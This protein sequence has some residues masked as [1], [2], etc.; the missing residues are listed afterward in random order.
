MAKKQITKGRKTVNKKSQ[1]ATKKEV[2]KI[3]QQVLNAD[4]E[5]KFMNAQS[6]TSLQPQPT[7][8]VQENGVW[9]PASRVSVLAFSNTV[10][11]SGNGVIQTYGTTGDDSNDLPMY[12]LEM[13]RPFQDTGNLGTKPY[14]IVGKEA[15]PVSAVNKWR[16]VRD[17]SKLL[18]GEYLNHQSS[19]G[20]EQ[21]LVA[22]LELT[23]SL[24]VICRMIRVSPKL[25]QTA[26]TV[27]PA[28]DLFLD[29]H[30]NIIG[31]ESGGFDDNEVLNYKIND[32]RYNVIQDKYFK[33]QNGLTVQWNRAVWSDG[34][35]NSRAMVQ[36][37]ITN[38]NGNC[39]K[40]LTTSHQL[41][42][43]KNGT[44]HYNFPT[45]NPITA[46]SGMRRE[47][48]LFHFV[49]AGAETYLNSSSTIN[50]CPTDLRVSNK[51]V[52]QFTDI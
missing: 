48:I 44:I 37:L 39:E 41:T 16:I 28:V 13:T 20:S 18:K 2:R 43:R 15:K 52:V 40:S 4:V 26:N 27:F 17:I 31:V 12:E 14:H 45:N 19:G 34:T 11:Q 5:R 23:T 24:P 32:R 50:T 30:S 49:Y 42:S 21:E 6:F 25:N 47:Y 1:L 51:N 22:P 35:N 9:K 29:T 10:N 38:T 36:P 46:T 33:I 3:A 7:Q 8:M